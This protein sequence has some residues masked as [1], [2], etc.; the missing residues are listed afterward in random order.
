MMRI[1]LEWRSSSSVASLQTGMTE[2]R[3]PKRVP[4]YWKLHDCCILMEDTFQHVQCGHWSRQKC[5]MTPTNTGTWTLLPVCLSAGGTMRVLLVY[6]RNDLVALVGWDDPKAYCLLF[7]ACQ[8]SDG[9]LPSKY[10]VRELARYS[11]YS[12]SRSI[13][14]YSIYTLWKRFAF[15]YTV[16]N[17]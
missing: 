15:V 3:S 2:C 11:K 4:Y 10:N 16:W 14:A 9:R 7:C 6:L 12:Y 17:G 5:G 13:Y 1:R 8:V